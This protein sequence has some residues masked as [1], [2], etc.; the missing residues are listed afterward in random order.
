MQLFVVVT[1]KQFSFVT[2][3]QFEILSDS[4]CFLFLGCCGNFTN[5]PAVLHQVFQ[6]NM[7]Q[8]QN[9]PAFFIPFRVNVSSRRIAAKPTVSAIN[10]MSGDFRRA[11][12]RFGSSH[13]QY[14]SFGNYEDGGFDGNYGRSH[15][16][17]NNF[18]ANRFR[19][20]RYSVDNFGGNYQSYGRRGGFRDY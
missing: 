18:G 3:N 12:N 13:S 11:G 8:L 19:S 14:N 15:H 17:W 16:A 5:F 1:A 6:G 9:S 7:T 20:N 4:G 10:D 2:A